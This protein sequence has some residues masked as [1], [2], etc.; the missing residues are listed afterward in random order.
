METEMIARQHPSAR[1]KEADSRSLPSIAL[2]QAERCPYADAFI[3]NIRILKCWVAASSDDRMLC[4]ITE[5]S[6]E[7]L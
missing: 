5:L 4:M 2:P 1:R 3:L 7:P 6:D